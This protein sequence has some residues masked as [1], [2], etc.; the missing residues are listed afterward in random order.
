MY[1]HALLIVAGV[2]SAGVALGVLPHEPSTTIWGTC[3]GVWGIIG[4][5]QTVR[6]KKFI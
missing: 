6:G 2:V 3:L 4:L 5:V 1:I